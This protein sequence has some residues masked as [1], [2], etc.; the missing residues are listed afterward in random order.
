MDEAQVDLPYLSI[1][2]AIYPS[3]NR[4]TRLTYLTSVSLSPH[5]SPALSG[6]QLEP[7]KS[8]VTSD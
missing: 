8:Q 7:S 6:F 2:E 1:S 4:A 3:K 5:W